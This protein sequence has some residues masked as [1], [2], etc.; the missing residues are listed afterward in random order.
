[1][2]LPSLSTPK[3]T[4]NLPSTGQEI[5]YRPFLVKEEKILLM[6]LEGNDD[7]EIQRAISSILESCII[8][9]IKISDLSVF[10]VEY[11]FLN[12]RGKSVG[13][14]IEVKIGHPDSECKH[15]TDVKINIDDIKVQGEISDGKIELSGGIGVKLK[16]PTIESATKYPT[17]TADGLFKMIA[18]CVDFVYDQEQ[19]YNDFTNDEM[20]QWLDGLDQ[21]SFKNVTKFFE[22]IPKLSHKI[23]WKCSAC[24]K[25]DSVL[26]EGI[27]NFFM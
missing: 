11:L 16:Y 13:E 9:D 14:V 26:L 23:E 27:N 10:D 21:N 25:T 7:K 18:S 19:V 15:Q 3:Y 6:A 17:D 5:E 1:M 24:G 2:G 22:S 12:L 20:V 8:S 4:T